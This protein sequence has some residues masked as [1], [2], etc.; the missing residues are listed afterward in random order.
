M[1]CENCERLGQTINELKKEIAELKAKLA[2]YESPHTPPSRRDFQSKPPRESS[3]KPGR[4]NGHEGITR[5]QSTPTHFAEATKETCPH[6]STRLGVSFDVER[7][8]VE[9]IPEPQPVKVIEFKIHY[10]R[11]PR[12]DTVVA[13]EHPDLPKEGNF[14]KNA[15]AHVTLMKY[16]D[17]LPFR[18]IQATL[19]R[20]FGLN[21][22][23]G[24]IFDFTRRVSDAVQ[25]EYEFILSRIRGSKIV[26]IDETGAKV[27]GTNYWLWAFTTPKE[28]FVVVR[29][30]RGTKVLHEVLTRRFKG[31]VVCDGWRSYP[32]FTKKLQRCWAHMLR[33]CRFIAE[34]I[35]EIQPLN[36]ALHRLYDKLTAFLSVKRTCKERRRLWYESRATLRRWLRR[37]YQNVEVKAFIEKVQNGFDHWFTFILHPE[38]EPTNNRAERALRE[39]VVQ[40]KIF[41]T[42]RNEKGARIYE[43]LVTI[44]ATWKQRGYPLHQKLVSYL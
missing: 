42:L 13:G 38:V 15:L 8:I 35:A 34:K 4:K 12:C 37:E 24:A 44:I 43:T 6:C 30:S 39:H 22:S 31:I 28:T 32:A 25:S 17:R 20:Q 36:E 40:R 19:Q 7:K 5:A 29:N 16:E 2:K 23:P 14:G 11:C 10:Y 26:Y 3:G 21:V 1:K 33:E 27:E 41:G 9:E 18:K